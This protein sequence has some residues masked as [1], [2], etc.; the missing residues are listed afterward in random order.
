MLFAWGPQ[1][2]AALTS[3]LKDCC[4]P[5]LLG[6]SYMHMFRLSASAGDVNAPRYRSSYTL[7]NVAHREES[8]AAMQIILGLKSAV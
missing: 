5:V 2:T 7:C 4:T 1:P 3:L 6:W 8:E